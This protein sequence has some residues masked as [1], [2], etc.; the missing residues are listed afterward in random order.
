MRITYVFPLLF[1]LLIPFFHWKSASF[2]GSHVLWHEI[3]F[4]AEMSFSSKY[5]SLHRCTTQVQFTNLKQL[6][7][8][9]V[10][11]YK[12]LQVLGCY[13]KSVISKMLHLRYCPLTV[14]LGDMLSHPNS[15]N[16]RI[17]L[18]QKKTHCKF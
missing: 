18:K 10:L 7:P 9:C 16:L 11:F 4:L 8:L 6:M 17:I 13:R 14:F 15:S 5:T 1:S 3:S 12:T 2:S